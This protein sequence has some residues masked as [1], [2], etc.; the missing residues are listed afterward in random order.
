MLSRVD[1]YNPLG[2]KDSEWK[3]RSISSG[4]LLRALNK[5]KKTPIQF[6]KFLISSKI[7]E[8]LVLFIVIHWKKLEPEEFHGKN[9]VCFI[10]PMMFHVVSSK[11]H[12]WSD[13]RNFVRIDYWSWRNRYPSLDPYKAYINYFPFR[14]HQNSRYKRFPYLPCS[15]E[16]IKCW[17]L[18]NDSFK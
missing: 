6:R 13:H 12:K 18:C 7:K 4:Y 15:T 5:N 17:L 2:I 14:N 16:W 10:K 8:C 3:W 9:C 11:W 1:K